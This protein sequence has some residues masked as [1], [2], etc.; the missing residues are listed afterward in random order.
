MC[1][2]QQLNTPQYMLPP[3]SPL[4]KQWPLT[5]DK[6]YL[7]HGS[8]GATPTAV[9]QA[10]SAYQLAMEAEAI[11][12]FIDEL[13][14]LI[15]TSKQALARYVHA[16]ANN[17][18]FVPNTTTGINTILSG[19]P[20]QAGQHWLTTNH[21]YGACASAFKHY[22]LLNGC[23]VNVANVP[24]PIQ[25][26]AQILQAIADAVTPQTT[27]ALI[28]F[29]TS[30]TATIFPVAAIIKHLQ[31]KNITVI[32]DAAHAPG[33]VDFSIENLAPDYLVANCHKWI[34]SPKGSAF[35]YVAPQHQPHIYPLVISHYNDTAIGTAAN[36]SNQH[37]WQ[38]TK[39]YSAYLAVKD[40]LDYLPTL[41]NGTWATVMAHNHHLVVQAA[42]LIANTLG[43]A[44][45]TPVSMVGSIC[46]I[47]MPNGAAPSHKFHS[48][49]ALKNTLFNKYN[50]EVMVTQ[51]PA[52]PTQ[53]LRISA[54]LYNSMAQYEYLTMCLQKIIG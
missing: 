10:Q 31:S 25:N 18:A 47:P 51:F 1:T 52:A 54:Q 4:G 44:L 16:D 43:V 11:V 24:Y 39:D 29:I 20:K 14:Q 21:A 26:E 37:L 32:I 8:F 35:M 3:Y 12:H 22:A 7:N 33:M 45:P 28:D 15:T 5:A 40:A 17:I 48:N 30:A 53:W 9:L 36:W 38:G 2:L 13:P 6:V 42:N 23:A 46:C 41:V 50:I 19:M 49:T 27:V 34:C